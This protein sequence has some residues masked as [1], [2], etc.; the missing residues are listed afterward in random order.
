MTDENKKYPEG[1]FVGQWIGIG[2]AIFSGLGIPISFIFENFAFIGIGPSI[3]LAFG[4]AIG[5]SIENKYKKEGRIRPQ[6]KQEKK[7]VRIALFIGFAFLLAG[8]LA[9]VMILLGK[10]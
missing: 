9:F 7:R 4:A 1:H 8:V 5:S 3:G 10:K 6:T 2:M